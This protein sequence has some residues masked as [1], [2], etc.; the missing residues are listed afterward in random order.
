MT[1]QAIDPV[2]A[3]SFAQS[4]LQTMN[5]GMLT[6]LISIGHQAGLFESL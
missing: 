6:L 5:Q 4:V 2:R 1:V 3:E